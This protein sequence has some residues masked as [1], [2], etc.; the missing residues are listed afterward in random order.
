M[1]PPADLVAL[2]IAA[3]AEVSPE[4]FSQYLL[5][6][7]AVIAVFGTEVL[8]TGLAAKRLGVFDAN[9]GKALGSAILK[10]AVF[11]SAAYVL[12]NYIPSFPHVPFL[13]LLGAC[14]PIAIY[15]LVFDCTMSQ[16]VLIWIAVLVVEL[17]AGF[18]LVY[19]AIALGAHL[20]ERFDLAIHSHTPYHMVEQQGAARCTSI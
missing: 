2:T 11:W 19:G 17:V 15:K 18:L 6:R 16:A 1:T 20:D 8:A 7:I 9:Y 5:I 14:A 13:V 12:V 10:N 3:Q 4:P